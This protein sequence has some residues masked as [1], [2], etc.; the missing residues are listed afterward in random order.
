MAV[1]ASWYA[2]RRRGDFMVTSCVH[3]VSELAKSRICVRIWPLG[4]DERAHIAAELL[5]SITS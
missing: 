3:V 2:G 4:A 1:A 5:A